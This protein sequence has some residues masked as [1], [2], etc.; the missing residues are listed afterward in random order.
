MKKILTLTAFVSILA[1]G[2]S[3]YTMEDRIYDYIDEYKNMAMQE[4]ELY[5]VP[6][7]ITLAQAIYASKAGSNRQ[8]MEANNHFG[9]MCHTNEWKGE[10]FY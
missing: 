5:K 8:A 4:M 1:V 7:S 3:Q 9:I 10:T 2:F 6:A